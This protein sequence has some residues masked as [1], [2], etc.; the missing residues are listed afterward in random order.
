MSEEQIGY[1]LQSNK[2]IAK[3]LSIAT[4]V[5]FDV[6]REL[7]SQR[8]KWGVQRHSSLAWLPILS[9]EVG[10]V[11]EALQKGTTAFKDTD[12]DDLEKELIQTAAVAI[13]WVASLRA[14][15]E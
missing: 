3:D 10:E 6:E 11:A 2:E 13:S 9:E 15:Q 7:V 8:Q 1:N 4:S 5:I 12:S 14:T